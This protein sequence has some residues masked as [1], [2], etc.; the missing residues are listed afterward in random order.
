MLQRFATRT[1]AVASRQRALLPSAAQLQAAPFSSDEFDV[2]AEEEGEFDDPIFHNFDNKYVMPRRQTMP[3]AA[4]KSRFQAIAPEN[5]GKV[6]RRLLEEFK[7]DSFSVEDDQIPDANL[8]QDLRDMNKETEDMTFADQDDDDELNLGRLGLL[9]QIVHVD[10][11]QKV[12]TQGNILRFRAMVVVGN[13]R[14]CAGYAVG[15]GAS[16]PEAILRGT[17]LAMKNY[18]FVDRFD[19]RTLYHEV[20]GKWN[21]C[22]LFLRPAPSGKGLTVSDT[23]ACVLDC[24]GI[25]DVVSKCHG[26]RNPYTVIR[27]TFNALTKHETAEEIA[28]KTGHSLVE[29]SKLA[30]ARN[31]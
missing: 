24:F 28:L 5:R 29:I 19:N 13:R 16:P 3:D 17:K 8:L 11:V 1:T 27:A 2:T 4:R 7:K 21:S 18:A 12:T 15:K 25:E 31:L 22:T 23:V 14:G 9:R 6:R 10:K 26:Q 30:K 20:R